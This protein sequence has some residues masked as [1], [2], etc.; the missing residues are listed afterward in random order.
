MCT[1]YWDIL[2]CGC[3]IYKVTALCAT[4]TRATGL[5]PGFF[6]ADPEG[7]PDISP[8]MNNCRKRQSNTDVDGYCKSCV[9]AA[10]RRARQENAHRRGRM[11]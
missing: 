3:G 7:N 1:E 10:E 6:T 2:E 9:A 8:H 5:E 4:V 11:Y